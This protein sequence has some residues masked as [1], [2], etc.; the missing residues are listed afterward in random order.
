[1]LKASRYASK[2]NVTGVSIFAKLEY[3]N[4]A[5]SVKDRIVRALVEDA[6]NKGKNIVVLL[7]DSGDSYLSSPLFSDE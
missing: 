7:P 1:M 2:A 5:V 4:L 6:E 3:F